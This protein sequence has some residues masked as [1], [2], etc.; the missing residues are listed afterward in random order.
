M[1]VSSLATFGIYLILAFIV[2]G[3]CYLFLF[4]VC[5]HDVTGQVIAWVLPHQQAQQ[6]QHPGIEFPTVFLLWSLT[7]VVGLLVS[8][9]TFA[10]ELVL[11]CHFEFFS[12]CFPEIH[13]AA[14]A[15]LETA[16][17]G[18]FFLYVLAGSA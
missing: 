7:V 6:K 11:R 18:S 10:L 16:G 5:F 3:F 13:T 4:S 2:P 14:I 17:K 9:L 8:S 12:K 1:E 15:Q